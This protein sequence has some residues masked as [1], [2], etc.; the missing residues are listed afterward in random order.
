MQILYCYSQ[1]A[2]AGGSGPEAALGPAWG[3]ALG[4]AGTRNFPRCEVWKSWV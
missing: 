3:V 1:G 2:G 4:G